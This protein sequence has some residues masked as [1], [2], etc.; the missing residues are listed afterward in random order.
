VSRGVDRGAV[1]ALLPT[2]AVASIRWTAPG[3]I[4]AS[5]RSVDWLVIAGTD[6]DID[7]IEIADRGVN[8]VRD[9]AIRAVQDHV[10]A[11]ETA[12]LDEAELA[13]RS[14]ALV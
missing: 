7:A 8:E 10:L 3:A 12:S 13:D 14:R 6:D 9:K 2:L 1:V 5:C 11:N 4:G